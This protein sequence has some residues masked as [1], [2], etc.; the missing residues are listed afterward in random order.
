MVA[1]ENKSI[2]LLQL[3]N[4]FFKSFVTPCHAKN[5]SSTT[6]NVEQ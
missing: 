3:L 5:K 1:R 6:E 2:K 4:V